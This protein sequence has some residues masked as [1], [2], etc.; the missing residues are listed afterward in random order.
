[1][2]K[3]RIEAGEQLANKLLEYKNNK[4]AIVVTI[5][6]GGLPIGH[7]I[8]KKLSLPLE[9]V[10]SKKIG[11][12][13]HKEFAIGAV[14][15]ND[16]ILSEDARDISNSYIDNETSRIRAILK[17]RQDM[18]YGSSTPINL[19]DKT[20]I[21]VDDGV[22]TGQT[23]ISSINLIHQQEPSQ[24]VVA[25]PV[26]PPLVITK[27]NN[28]S[29]VKNTI[30]LLTPSNFQAVGQFYKEFYQVDDSEVIRLLKEANQTTIKD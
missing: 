30:C 23:L 27:I 15:L 24:I 4:K 1:M 20:V 29:S 10:L 7:I 9:I 18:Y 13:L 6:R 26:G 17:Q 5:P 21:L 11:H 22:A 25:L 12:P 2:F 16:I 28:M 3:D 19:K 14:T 8:A